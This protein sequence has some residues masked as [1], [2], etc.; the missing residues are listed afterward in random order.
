VPLPAPQ[1]FYDFDEMTIF[2]ILEKDRATIVDSHCAPPSPCR[3]SQ[4]VY[5]TAL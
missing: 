5:S 4:P 3:N 1:S 2:L